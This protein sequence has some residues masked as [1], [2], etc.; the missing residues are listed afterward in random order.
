MLFPSFSSL[1]FHKIME[2]RA[3]GELQYY[4][5]WLFLTL[6]LAESFLK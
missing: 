2:L 1:Q 4:G 5:L 3:W 6:F